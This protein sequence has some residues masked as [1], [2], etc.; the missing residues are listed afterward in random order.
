[1][2]KIAIIGSGISGLS[3]AYY[4]KDD[5]EITLFEKQERLGGNS[6]TI[7]IKNENFETIVDT[8]FIVLNDRNYPNLIKLFNDLNIE[9]HNTEMTF[10]VSSKKY[11]WSGDNLDS[12][13]AQRKN[14]FNFVFL[15]G[16][17]DILKFNK[18]AKNI[19]EQ[20]SDI[21][22]G[23]LI[24]KLKMGKWFQDHYLYPMGASIWSSD[25][26]DIANFPA[27]S[28]IIFFEN[29]GLLYINNRPQWMSL[30]N[31][32]IEYVSKLESI[33]SKKISI[34]KNANIK[35]ILS[36][37]GK[38]L[39]EANSKKYEFD[40]IIFSNHPEE[41]LKIL[42]NPSKEEKTTLSKFSQSKNIAYTHNDIRFMPHL[43][44][45]WACW[46]FKYSENINESSITYWMNKLQ[47]INNKF[48][49]LVTLN[50]IEKIDKKN[51]FDKFTFYHPIYDMNSF[52]G[53]KGIKKMQGINNIYYCGS[54]IKNG[55][56]EDGISSALD[57]INEIRK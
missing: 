15:K 39:L 13:F 41:I 53:Q 4:L 33:L 45:C 49:I 17:Y 6:R 16:L 52:I 24:S 55:F 46:N 26:S 50:P 43:R 23:E 30:K 40:K 11:E 35:S 8:G 2:K 32:S 56:H 31:K 44:K 38:I 47:N 21:T 5:F 27:K 54:Y 3:S 1:M 57:V 10:S 18:H 29:H 20:F 14:I 7:Q 34:I 22:M 28:F 36:S 12:I 25:A 48:P 19:V 37:D 42:K 51:I 9:L